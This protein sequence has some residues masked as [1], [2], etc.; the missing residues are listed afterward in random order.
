MADS[1]DG[2]RFGV[3]FGSQMLY[4]EPQELE[5]VYR[6]CIR[7]GEFNIQSWGQLAMNEIFPLWLLKSLPNM[8][9]CHI[10]IAHDARGPCNSIVSGDSSGLRAVLEA[11][12][13][14]ARGHADVMIAGGVSSRLSVSPLVYRGDAILSHRAA[15]PTAASRPFDA[16]RDGMVNGEGGGAFILESRDHAAKRGAKVR[17]QILGWGEG[18]EPR[19]KGP[20]PTGEG[21]RIAMHRALRKTGLRPADLDHVNAHGL[22]TVQDDPL[23]AQAIRDCVGDTPVT[24]PKSYFGNLGAGSPVVEMAAS[25]LAIEQ[26]QV[27]VTLN[28]ETPDPACPVNVIRRE[29][30]P[31]TKSA[32]MNLSQSGTGQTTALV[33]SDF[34]S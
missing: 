27:P 3:V 16:D 13:I 31:V 10:G 7:D 14:I 6:G 29:P 5:S 17:G 24:A 22:G 11:A 25:V 2:D 23:E 34:R 9:A 1:I 30:K 28:Y 33:I 20:E 15:N 12:H 8:I 18:F 26:R 21:F 32:V 4:F 19:W